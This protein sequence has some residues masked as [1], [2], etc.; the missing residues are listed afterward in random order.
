M[1]LSSDPDR[2]YRD[3]LLSSSETR[4]RL[5]EGRWKKSAG[6]RGEQGA[7]LMDPT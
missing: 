6:G 7:H 1:V 5:E 2:L 4:K 3:T